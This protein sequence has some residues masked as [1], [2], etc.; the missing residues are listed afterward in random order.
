MFIRD[1]IITDFMNEFRRASPLQAAFALDL[2][3]AAFAGQLR[4]VT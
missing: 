1:T 3:Q 4:R 2:L